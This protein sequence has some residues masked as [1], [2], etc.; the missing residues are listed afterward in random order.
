[1]KS[2]HCQSS[3]VLL[4]GPLRFPF[5]VYLS[6][7]VFPCSC[8]QLSLCCLGSSF[9]KTFSTWYSITEIELMIASGDEFVASVNG[10]KIYTTQT[11]PI[12]L[13][14]EFDVL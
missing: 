5:S 3:V 6:F 8:S 4:E 12:F 7:L 13:N 10:I 11:T 9:L 2:L 1:M 14:L